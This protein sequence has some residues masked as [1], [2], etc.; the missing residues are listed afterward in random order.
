MDN[1]GQ[2]I[3]KLRELRNYTQEYMALNLD[4]TQTAYCKLEKEDSRL[5]IVRLKRIADVL[6]IEPLQLLTFNEKL[7][8]PQKKQAEPQREQNSKVIYFNPQKTAEDNLNHRIKNLENEL[9]TLR[10][11]IGKLSD[12]LTTP[13]SAAS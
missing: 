10:N 5:S 12:Q 6:D 11:L 8:I 1:V 13:I 7:F 2:K 3:R 9:Y 4:I